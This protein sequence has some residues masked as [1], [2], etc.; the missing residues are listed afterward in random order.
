MRLS[1]PL[2]L[3]FA[4]V[5]VV[6]GSTYVANII[7][8]ET[9][10]PFVLVTARLGIA[11]ALALAYARWRVRGGR[12]GGWRVPT[13]PQWRNLLITSF[14]F[15]TV[16]LGAVVWSEQFIESSTA[17]LLVALEPLVV[18]L[19]LWLLDGARPRWQAFL[20][21]ALGIAGTAML[22]GQ[23]FVVDGREGWWGVGAVL[24]AITAWAFGSVFT[25]RWD[26]GADRVAAAGW[27]MLLAAGLSVPI[28]L[29][30][31]EL[32]GF[33]LAGVSETSWW[34]FA[35]LVVFGSIVAYTA[36]LYLLQHVS[37]EKVATS[38]YVH[39]IVALILGVALRGEPVG[40]QTLAACAVML[41][42]VVFVNAS[43]TAAEKVGVE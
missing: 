10:P 2:L 14:L 41:T 33:T 27:Q 7:A 36:F 3:A 16:G 28:A 37:P 22:V 32:V 20:G 23:D 5:Y 15:F 39:P 31:G 17:A 6:W 42:G 38:T 40:A 4:I 43:G 11:G 26:L 21:V 30:S 29:A 19:V 8:I 9:I 34:A 1:L 35:F 13:R 25:A 24:V 12:L 18:V